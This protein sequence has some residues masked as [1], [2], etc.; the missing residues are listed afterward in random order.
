ME[1]LA[2]AVGNLASSGSTPQT[3]A[4]PAASGRGATMDNNV[5][6]I[7]WNDGG[8]APASSSQSRH[9]AEETPARTGQPSGNA[10]F[11]VQDSRT[12]QFD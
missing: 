7:E 10:P 1:D 9:P 2:A 6:Q 5:R 11:P 12:I 3:T 8:A 4:G